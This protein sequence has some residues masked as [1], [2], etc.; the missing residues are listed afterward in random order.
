MMHAIKQTSIC[1]VVHYWLLET[2]KLIAAV[3]QPHTIPIRTFE[4]VQ[5]AKLPDAGPL[6]VGGLADVTLPD[7]GRRP[8]LVGRRSRP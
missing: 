1:S 6:C 3:P 2:K 8:E 4:L 5:K 7:E